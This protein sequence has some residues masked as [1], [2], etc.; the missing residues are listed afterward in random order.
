MSSEPGTGDGHTPVDDAPILTRRSVLAVPLAGVLAGCQPASPD[1]NHVGWTGGFVGEAV[2]SGH[3][4]RDRQQPVSASGVPPSRCDVVIIG[5]GIAGLSAA[6]GL[7]EAGVEDI[8]LLELHD[9]VGGNSRAHAIQGRSCPIGAHYLPVPEPSNR[10]LMRWLHEIGLARQ[11]LGRTV[12]DER[13][14]CHSPQE[15]VWHDGQWHEGL[16][17]PMSSGSPGFVQAQRL[18][19]AMASLAKAVDFQMPSANVNWT[20]MHDQL[21]RQSFARWLDEQ[22]IADDLLRWYLDYCCLDDYGAPA[23][24]VSAWA[25]VHY[26]ASRRGFAAPGPEDSTHEAVFTWPE[27][28][29]WLVKRLAEPLGDRLQ[30]GW[31]ASQITEHR[32]HVEVL[33]HRS[34]P[35]LPSGQGE[36]QG[37]GL[38]AAQSWRAR[39]VVLALPLA[40][41]N[42]LLASPPPALTRLAQQIS[43]SP[44]LVAN[45]ELSKE[46]IERPGVPTAWDNVVAGRGSLG[47]VD[48]RHQTLGQPDQRPL[49]TAYH[50]WPTTQR[51]QLLERSWADWSRWVVNDLAHVHA[52]LPEKVSRV[53]ITRHGHAMAI[54][55]PGLRGDPDLAL[56]RSQALSARLHLAHADLSGYSVFEESFALGLA[57]GRRVAR[58]LGAK[59]PRSMR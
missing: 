27:G 30:T 44:W 43:S 14:L 50:A 16:L 48:A 1:P 36:R 2:A 22:G 25:G 37:V 40:W 21:D 41:A 42:R 28:N 3:R 51:G 35:D 12:F 49:L 52:D 13:H 32:D 24:A 55:R 20:A 54:P 45:L 15:R 46:L 38:G 59:T 9:Q 10:E 23:A 11:S 4:W 58:A 57:S 18:S 19:Q 53:D 31:M 47:Y 26:F 29:Q 6:R 7:R 8:V 39:Q 56:W 5:A 34:L 17:P 33:A